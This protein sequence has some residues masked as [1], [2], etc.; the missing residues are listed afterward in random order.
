MTLACIH[1]FGLR[2]SDSVSLSAT[3]SPRLRLPPSR[4]LSLSALSL[5]LWPSAAVDK[6]YPRGNL[7]PKTLDLV[8]HHPDP[9]AMQLVSSAE[10][11]PSASPE[12]RPTRPALPDRP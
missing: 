2:R 7:S 10:L 6:Q 9:G 8:V 5:A 1:A 12:R 11:L 4:A 3:C